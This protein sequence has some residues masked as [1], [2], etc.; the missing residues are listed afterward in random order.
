MVDHVRSL[1]SEIRR[2]IVE[3]GP[4]S[5][6]QFM[7]L[8]LSHPE[9]GYYMTR[10]PF[11]SAG[12]F[13]TAPE[14]SQIFGELIGV[15]AAEIWRLMGRPDTLSLIELGPGRGTLMRDALR[16]AK[17]VADFRKALRVHLVETSPALERRQR[18]TLADCGAAIEWHPSLAEVPE[19]P[20]IIVANEFFDALPVHQIVKARDGWHER[21]VK[22]NDSLELEFGL[23]AE[24]LPNVEQMLP[25][26]VRN[27]PCGAIYEWRA[28]DIAL[29]VSR[30]AL[31]G[32]A[33]V[34]DYGHGE[35]APGDTLQAMRGHQYC[36]PLVA[37]GSSDLTAHVDFA[38]LARSAQRAGARVHGPIEQATFLRQLGIDTRATML[39]RAATSEQAR[40]IDAA[41]ARLTDRGKAGMGSMF[42]VIAFSH[43]QLN[44]LPG[45]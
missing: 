41:V 42:K 43:P 34:I 12:D 14:I 30:R 2:R 22:L 38:A 9:H 29:D 27:A 21:V 37:P 33:L 32:A 26:G 39:K 31:R 28:D 11:G 36:D 7:E 4:M 24:P 8:G 25:L 6:S 19:A 45:F 44:I 18:A 1:E 40:E 10:D 3:S 35:S 23:A 5:V 17:T 13:V 20:A 16:A 15:W